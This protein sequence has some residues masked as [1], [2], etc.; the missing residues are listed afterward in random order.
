[1]EENKMN[2]KIFAFALPILLAL[3]LLAGTPTALAATTTLSLQPSSIA[4]P[5]STIGI[6]K[7]FTVTLHV[8]NVTNLW[9]WKVAIKWDPTVLNLTGSPTEGPFLKSAGSTLFLVASWNASMIPEMSDTLLVAKSVNGSGDLATMSFKVLGPTS[10]SSIAI[11][12]ATMLTPSPH[13]QI[14]FTSTGVT[15]LVGGI[16]VPVNKLELL[17]PYIGLAIL[18]AVAFTTVGY[19]KKKYRD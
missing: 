19:V 13:Q 3:L 1:M 7:N 2:K 10:S 14:Q 11:I 12:N 15:L 9:S 8:A 16:Y 6:G 5:S 17:A 4:G 18:L